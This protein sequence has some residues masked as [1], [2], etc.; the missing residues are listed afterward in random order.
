MLEIN[1]VK[2]IDKTTDEVPLTILR[3]RQRRKIMMR[4]TVSSPSAPV[5]PSRKTR[6]RIKDD[7]M[8]TASKIYKLKYY[9]ESFDGAMKIIYIVAFTLLL[10]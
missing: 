6:S 8:T 3:M 2:I 9:H 1:C 5:T 10:F 7:M 4:A